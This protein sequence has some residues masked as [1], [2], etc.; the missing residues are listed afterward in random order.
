MAAEVELEDVVAVVEPRHEG[1]QLGEAIAAEAVKHDH[2]GA[3]LAGG[4]DQPSGQGDAV[5]GREADGLV[6]EADVGRTRRRA[7]RV[8]LER[9]HD[10]A[11]EQLGPADGDVDQVGDG[12]QADGSAEDSQDAP[13]HRGLVNPSR[14]R[15]IARASHC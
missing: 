9:T 4:W 1:L 8:R 15:R 3:R 7:D 6:V 10:R 2:R 11:D 13:D 12:D 5:I 14:A